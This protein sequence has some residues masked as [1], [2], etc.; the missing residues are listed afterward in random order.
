MQTKISL[1]ESDHSRRS[2]EHKNHW[3]EIKIQDS[4]LDQSVDCHSQNSNPFEVESAID[5]VYE[6]DT[7]EITHFIVKRQKS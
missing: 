2:N 7:P 4:E 3:E 6:D 1:L 5:E